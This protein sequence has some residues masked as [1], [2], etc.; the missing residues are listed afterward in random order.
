MYSMWITTFLLM[1]LAVLASCAKDYYEVLGISRSATDR[2]IKKAFRKLAVQYHPDKNQEPGAEEKFREIAEAY[3][4]LSDEDKKREYDHMGHAAFTQKS[5]GGGGGHHNHAFHFNFD[6]LF[7]DFDFDNDFGNFA[8]FGG[9]EDFHADHMRRHQQAH[10]KAH[11]GGG[12]AHAFHQQQRRFSGD[13]SGGR[14][15]RTVTQRVG[16]MVTTYTTCS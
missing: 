10:K 11:F 5:S 3:E 15:C 14:T 9:F 1:A 8:D 6:D 13:S 12:Q 2:E 16:N 4:T 7:R